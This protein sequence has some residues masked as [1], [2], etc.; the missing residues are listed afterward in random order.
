[1]Q[2]MINRDSGHN[3]HKPKRPQTETATDRNGHKPKRPQ[4]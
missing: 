4:T 1:M 2:K 3:G